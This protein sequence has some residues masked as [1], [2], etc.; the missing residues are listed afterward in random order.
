MVV[1]AHTVVDHLCAITSYLRRLHPELT[2]TTLYAE[3][4]HAY[5]HYGMRLEDCP[6]DP[7]A[8]PPVGP[9]RRGRQPD[10][11]RPARSVRWFAA[12]CPSWRKGGAK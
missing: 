1:R 10:L 8:P 3:A 4:V 11:A 12:G 7:A 2:D 5:R 6:P 9:R